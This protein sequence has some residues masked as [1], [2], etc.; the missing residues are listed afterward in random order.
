ME[1]ITQLARQQ[2]IDVIGRAGVPK[3]ERGFGIVQVIDDTL[4]ISSGRI[5]VDG[6]MCNLPDSVV[7]PVTDI[8]EPDLVTISDFSPNDTAFAPDQYVAFMAEGFDD[9]IARIVAVD[10]AFSPW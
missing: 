4:E 2:G 6:I 5:Y 1:I 9:R 8:P 7:L 3:D 10:A